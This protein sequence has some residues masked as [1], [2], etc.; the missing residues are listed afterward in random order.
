MQATRNINLKETED[1][2]IPPSTASLG[3]AT[4]LAGRMIVNGRTIYFIVIR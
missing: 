3:L 2:R 4:F 1:L